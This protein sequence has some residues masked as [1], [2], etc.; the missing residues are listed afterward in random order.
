MP[1]ASGLFLLT[2]GAL[3]L[4]APW[5]DL[6]ARRSRVPQVS[7]LLL[8]GVL[9]GPMG[10]D[11]L[12]EDRDHWLPVVTEVAL[13]MV[14][15]L[16]G[17]ELKA[18]HL[19]ARGRPVVVI[20]AVV[21]VGTL[22]VVALGLLAVGTRPATALVLATAATATDP[23]AVDSV[24]RAGHHR[25][26]T[27]A[28]L[29]GIVAVDDVWGL[30]LFGLLLSVLS[31]FT[32]AGLQPTAL[33]HALGELGGS[34]LLGGGLGL[35]ATVLLGRLRPG[36]PTRLEVLGLVL[37]ACGLASSLGLS[38]LLSAVAMGAVFANTARH[39]EAPIR[40]LES[41][42]TPFLVLFFVLS[43][44]SAAAS[45]S[46]QG[47]VLL[48]AYILLRTA[49]RL[50]GGW[51]GGRLAGDH[52]PAAIGGALLPQ[53]GVALGMTLVAAERAP[54]VAGDVLPVVILSTLG[55]EGLGPLAT[56][57]LM[58]RWDGPGATER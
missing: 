46:G 52:H 38:Y 30:L 50:L 9:L 45:I 10:L 33:V 6:V 55:F 7:L 28:L 29:R 37:V 13:A 53:A 2:T 43:G 31:A 12:P 21:S 11:L 32:G 35:A 36:E 4:A 41:L 16:L 57:W 19:R 17:G 48:G 23:A 25:G 51:L 14:G 42:E 34:V 44:A 20:S 18:S 27:A 15:F 54:E 47:W 26:P 24:L 39:V 1:D 49:G 22:L 5:V 3:I 58:A 8:L 56:S 40:A